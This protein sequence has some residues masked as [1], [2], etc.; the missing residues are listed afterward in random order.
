MNRIPSNIIEQ[1]IQLC[2]NQGLV[3]SWEDT[4]GIAMIMNRCLRDD[5]PMWRT[6]NSEDW[7]V[8]KENLNES[9][10]GFGGLTTKQMQTVAPLLGRTYVFDYKSKRGYEG[11]RLCLPKDVPVGFDPE[12]GIRKVA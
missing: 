8:T 7:V 1:A 11:G 4:Y 2:R 10:E 9:P 6:N 12:Y 5:S 3:K